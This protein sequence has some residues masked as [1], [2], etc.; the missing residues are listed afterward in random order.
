MSCDP[1]H[2]QV[3]TQHIWLSPNIY[4]PT[5]MVHI[6]WVN[7]YMLGD[8]CW[9]TII[10]MLGNTIYICWVPRIYIGQHGI[11]IGYIRW[12]S[13]IYVGYICWRTFYIPWVYLLGNITYRLGICVGG[14]TIYLGYIYWVRLQYRYRIFIIINNTFI[15]NKWRLDYIMNLK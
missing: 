1:T 4:H 9:V 14:R 3:C 10:Y 7:T 6:C 8:I 13:T 2:I 12:V 5:Y 15:I 11:C